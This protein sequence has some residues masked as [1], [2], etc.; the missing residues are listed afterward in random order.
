MRT[1]LAF[2][3]FSMLVFA[4][5]EQSYVQT[6]ARDGSSVIEKSTSLAIFANIITNADLERMAQVCQKS[7]S[8]RCSV[9]AGSKTVMMGEDFISG[10]YY[11]YKSDSGLPF[12][13]HSVMI[14]RIATD[15]FSIALDKLLIT[16]NATQA[17]G[18]GAT[19]RPIDLNARDENR[20]NAALLRS[21][22]ANLT[23]TIIMPMPISEA[24]AGNVSGSVDGNI[25]VFN[26][27]DVI[28]ESAPIVVKSSELN[29]GY[30]VAI[31]GIIALASLA[32]SFF[33][34]KPKKRK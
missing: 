33:K 12:T 14:N 1:F 9:D 34:M 17:A 15:R 29:A 20:K 18:G 28:G 10:G 3:L 6:V 8:L 27:V 26:L 21:I 19:V 24:R 5:M 2:L 22:K 25:A 30:L 11:T 23:Y 7:T 31:I 13:T 32:L 16:S 4:P